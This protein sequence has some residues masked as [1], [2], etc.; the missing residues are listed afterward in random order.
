[1]LG[2]GREFFK[3]FVVRRDRDCGAARG[4]RLEQGGGERCAF[5][6]IGA[7]R[8]LVEQDQALVRSALQQLAQA[9]YVRAE[10]RQRASEALLVTDVGQ[11]TIEPA[12]RRLL[13]DRQRDAGAR[14]PSDQAKRLERNG[15]ATGVGP[16]DH[17]RARGLDGNVIRDHGLSRERQQR[18]A[19]GA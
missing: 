10:G 14:H 2:V 18:M 3:F 1:M 8:E 6:R 17:E 7:G 13:R 19:R 4:E 12:D 16:G 11:H 5:L 9:L 15:L